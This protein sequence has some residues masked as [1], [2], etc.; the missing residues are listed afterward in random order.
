MKQTWLKTSRRSIIWKIDS[1]YSPPYISKKFTASSSENALEIGY[2]CELK[3]I[4]GVVYLLCWNY[5]AK[6]SLEMEFC[7]EGSIR[8]YVKR[9]RIPE[10]VLLKMFLSM[11]ETLRKIHEKRIVH[12]AIN[13]DNLLVTSDLRVK[14]ADFGHA[15]LIKAGESHCP[16][17]LPNE[18][19]KS[20]GFTY[21]IFAQDLHRLGK[22][23]YQ[24][25]VG[26]FEVQVL[27]MERSEIKT[28]CRNSGYTPQVAQ[29]IQQLLDVRLKRQEEVGKF[30]LTLE[31]QIEM[32][33]AL[34]EL[35]HCCYRCS[36]P[37]SFLQCKCELWYC[38][39]CK[40][41]ECLVCRNTFNEPNSGL[42]ADYQYRF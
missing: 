12:R 2:H 32:K 36:D 24:M 34:E 9:N 4:E 33:L 18:Q 39:N 6:P 21:R 17:S 19:G 16:N 5:G 27:E 35:E 11:T 22:V 15:K 31:V 8:M 14:F 13:C 42:Q 37:T 23:F 26:D 30:L 7:Q 38:Q 3:D 10:E 41:A 40:V 28:A 1:P 29:S 20:E 25:A